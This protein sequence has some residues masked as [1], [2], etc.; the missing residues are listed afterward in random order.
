MQSI[1][2]L[3][4]LLT[5]LSGVLIVTLFYVGSRLVLSLLVSD[6]PPP[7]LSNLRAK[8][9]ETAPIPSPARLDPVSPGQPV[10]TPLPLPLSQRV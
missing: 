2:T 5:V 3:F 6:T 10:S 7:D 4:S 8:V 1:V 9:V